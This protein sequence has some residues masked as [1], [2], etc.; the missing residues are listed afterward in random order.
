MVRIYGAYSE[1]LPCW[2]ISYK[3]GHRWETSAI[4]S[5]IKFLVK[6]LVKHTGYGN[7]AGLLAR[8]GLMC[9]SPDSEP[10]Q[11]S[12]DDGDESDT[13]EYRQNAHM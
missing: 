9:G 11:Y 2:E 3:E 7:A 5:F 10:N 8:R 1:Y 13:E 12:E 4:N 6:R